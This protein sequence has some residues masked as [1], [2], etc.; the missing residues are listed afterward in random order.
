MRGLLVLLSLLLLLLKPPDSPCSFKKV[1]LKT[2]RTACPRTRWEFKRCSCARLLCTAAGRAHPRR[3]LAARC[4]L[5]LVIDLPGGG[6]SNSSHAGGRER[7]TKGADTFR[8]S[9]GTLSD[10][11]SAGKPRPSSSPPPP[12]PSF[13]LLLI[14][15]R[16]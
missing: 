14:W 15:S 1:N 16:P 5:R 2:F 3:I 6:A 4:L 9:T 7:R 11:V 13:S 8:G 10:A 12:P